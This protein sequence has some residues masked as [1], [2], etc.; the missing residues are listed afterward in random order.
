MMYFPKKKLLCYSWASVEALLSQSWANL[1]P[2]LSQFW[3][4]LQPFKLVEFPPAAILCN[5]C[6]ELWALQEC[7]CSLCFATDICCECMERKEDSV[8]EFAS[9]QKNQL[10]KSQGGGLGEEVLE[11]FHAA[12][13]QSWLQECLS[14]LEENEDN[15]YGQARLLWSSS[16][17]QETEEGF[18]HGGRWLGNWVCWLVLWL[19]GH[20]VSANLELFK[21]VHLL[22]AVSVP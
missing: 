17:H 2:I 19:A 9:S 10:A 8:Q 12:V 16:E 3:A 14:F 6:Q 22:C 11:A 21:R 20:C 18:F 7:C 13:D 5:D 15:Q 4:N 1:E